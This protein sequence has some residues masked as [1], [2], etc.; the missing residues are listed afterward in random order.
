MILGEVF[1]RFAS[2]SPV[3]V[4]ARAALEH[5][6]PPQAI[7]ELFERVAERQYTDILL[8]S[9]VVDLLAAVVC[10]VRSAVNSA[11]LAK[12]ETFGVSLKAVYEKLNRTEPEVSA[13]LLRQ[14]AERLGPVVAALGGERPG[15]VDGLRTKI[16]DGNHFAGT[17]HRLK[18]LRAQRAGA[19]PGQA[20]VVL[21]PQAMLATD[22]FGCEDGHAQ[23]RALLGEV[24][25]TVRAG[26]LW[27]ADRGFCT[28]NFLFGI[29]ERG[30]RFAIRQH[31]SSCR[32]ER[33]DEPRPCG[34][35]ETGEVA[36]Q[37][38]RLSD[39]RGGTLPVRRVTIRLDRPTREGEAEIHV[40]TNLAESEATAAVV[41]EAY[42]GRRT[43]EGAFGELAACL[44]GEIA[45]PAYP[46]AALL[47][48]CVALVASNM[49]SVVRAS[50]RA[51]HGEQ[52]SEDR[53][54]TYHLAEELSATYRG[55]MI[56]IPEPEWVA[57]ATLTAPEL[58]SVLRELAGR[59]RLS[60]IRKRRRGPK[61]PRPPRQSGAKIKHVSTARI[62]KTREK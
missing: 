46:R 28:T 50:L 56:A 9:S 44:D 42:R 16:I 34:R 49:L 25:P 31:A 12:A 23:E 8:F 29:A 30:G 20:L 39:G 3:S 43:I 1:E 10:R 22:V 48:F 4:M 45:T 7:D 61:R 19:L 14:S 54:S 13:A 11:Y 52:A 59:V 33:V 51:A 15:P 38:A 18:G 21:D 35:V 47:A 53:V 37:D 58:A 62:L 24:L 6:L 17:E 60:S 2:D 27:V 41:A 32:I 55:M 5:A 36:E 40:L 26:E 57:F